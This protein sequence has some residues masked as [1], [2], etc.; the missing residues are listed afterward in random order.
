MFVTKSL[1]HLRLALTSN[2]PGQDS[3]HRVSQCRNEVFCFY[4]EEEGHFKGT[5]PRKRHH[6]PIFPKE[7][8]L[9]SAQPAWATTMF[10]EEFSPVR[11]LLPKDNLCCLSFC[12]MGLSLI[13]QFTTPNIQLACIVFFSVTV[14][15]PCR[16]RPLP[17]FSAM[18]ISSQWL[19]EIREA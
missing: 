4:C 14:T 2:S 16:I 15:A 17:S 5:C 18:I 13:C 1:R 10:L 7:N 8:G 6:W 12:S 3:G 11:L 19:L 9:S